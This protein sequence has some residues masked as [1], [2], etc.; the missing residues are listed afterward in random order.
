[1]PR[2]R[3]YQVCMH[4]CSRVVT[5]L[6]RRNFRFQ[7]GR[8][9]HQPGRLLERDYLRKLVPDICYTSASYLEKRGG[10]Q[11]D[12]VLP[13]SFRFQHGRVFHQLDRLLERGYLR[14]LVPD[15]CYTSASYLV[16]PLR[17][18]LLRLLRLLFHPC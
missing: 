11:V 7:H 18:L 8:V 4:P 5:F 12:P 6:S 10:G 9:F 16:L 17:L 13:C 3:L 15:I 14:K 2:I 1:M